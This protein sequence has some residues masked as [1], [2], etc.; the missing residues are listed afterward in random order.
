VFKVVDLDRSFEIAKKID[1]MFI[2]SLVEIKIDMEKVFVV[3][4]AKQ[5]GNIGFII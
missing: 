3:G 5:V 1:V 2:N 4:F